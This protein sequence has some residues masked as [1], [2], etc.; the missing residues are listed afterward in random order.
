MLHL[1]PF[2]T[3]Y[4]CALAALFGACMGSFLNCTAWRIVRGE[5]VLRGRSH[6]DACGHVLGARDLVPVVSYLVSGGKCRYC[7]AK[8]SRRHVWGEIVSAAV[9]VSLLLHYDISLRLLEAWA[10]AGI[11][12]ACSF[13]DLEGYIIPDRFIAAGVALFIASLFFVSE[14]LR[15]L[16]DGLLGGFGVAL[17]LLAVVTVLERRMGR[18][19]MGGGDLKLLFVTGLFFGWKGNLF[20][21]ILACIFGIA[22]GLL[23]AKRGGEKGAPIPWGLS[24]ALGAWVTAL[25]GEPFIHWYLS[26]L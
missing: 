24:I 13:A 17:G 5:S 1:T 16:V 3:A 8:L 12:L 7:G 14:P 22:F 2:I 23:A 15:R 19:A 4:C 9:F 26:L 18:E 6:C 21:L 11:L 10:L 20:C 25:A